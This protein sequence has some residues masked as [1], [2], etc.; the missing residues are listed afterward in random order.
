M[1]RTPLIC[2]FAAVDA[3]IGKQFLQA[4]SFDLMNGLNTLRY[5]AGFADKV[6]GKTIEV[7]LRAY[8]DPFAR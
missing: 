6:F 2:L 7:S 3:H 5:Y 1:V 8:S 4:K